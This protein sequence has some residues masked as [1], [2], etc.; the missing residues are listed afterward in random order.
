MTNGRSPL[1][2]QTLWLIPIIFFMFLGASNATQGA[3]EFW[4]HRYGVQVD[5]A[6][7]EHPAQI[8]DLYVYGQ[9][10]GE[11]DYFAMDTSARPTLLWIH[12]GGWVAGDKADEIS[13]LIPYLRRGWN[14]VNMN[15]RQ[16]AATAPSA[17][18]DVMCA[19]RRVTEILESTGMPTDQIVVSGASAGGHLALMVGVLSGS[20]AHP[21]QVASAPKAVVNW[22]GITDIEAV[23][24]FLSKTKPEA[25][26]AAAWIGNLDRLAQISSRYSPLFLVAENT[27]PIITIHGDLDTVV[28]YEQAIALHESL[29]TTNRLITLQGGT[30][31]GFSDDQYQDAYRA[32]FKFLDDL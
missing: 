8:F 23:H 5:V 6:Y 10:I 26:Y 25:N 4:G 3:D 22:F 7:G 28:P 32:I 16:G 24:A 1:R 13:R 12:G 2:E 14:V 18:D 15:Y 9:R 27:P 19:Y 21:C 29:S 30:H 11:P 31:G 20:G 17:V